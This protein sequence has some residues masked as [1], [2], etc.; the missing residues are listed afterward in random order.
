MLTKQQK[1]LLRSEVLSNLDIEKIDELQS[2]RSSLVNEL[3]QIVNRV[4]NKS[5]AYLTSADTLVMAE[6]VADEIEGYGPLRDL[7]ADDTINDILVNGPNDIWVERAG[8]LEKTDKEFVSN[9]QLTDIAKRL[10]ARVGRRIDDGSPLVDSRLPDGSRLNVVIAP[11]ALDG[12]SIS[13]RK[14]SKN[15]KTLQELVNFGSMTREMANFL[16]IAARSRVNIIVSGGTGSGKTTL[17]N[18]LSNYISHTERVITLED[19]AEL[20]LEQ[21]HVVRLETRLAGVEHTGEVTMQDLVINALRMRPER[22]IVGEC[23]GGEAFQMLQAMNTGHDGSM[24]TLHANSPRDATSRL[25][26]MVMMSNASLP[27]EA[28]RRNISSAVN[29][30]VQASRLND[31]SRK[32]MNITEVMGM[33]NGQIV[34]QDIFSYKASKYRDKEGKILGEFINHGLLTRS[35][36]FQNAQVF[37]LSAELQSIFGETE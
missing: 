2:E 6:I 10:V 26:S 9:E 12:T 15:K 30:I 23:R 1:I 27:L 3:V 37:N 4:A 22:I 21:P 11:I 24:S 33:E 36:V 28:I 7:M 16:I 34:L 20:R 32:I 14:F 18:A 5:G 35:V 25:E 17:L 29:I 19:T 31:G 8:I 13:I